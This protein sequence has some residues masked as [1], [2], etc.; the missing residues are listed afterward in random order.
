MP[1][2][3]GS[4]V[5]EKHFTQ[6]RL[7]QGND[8]YHAFTSEDLLLFREREEQINLHLGSGSPSLQSQSK[9]L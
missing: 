7:R 2:F 4:I 5:I 6:S 8:H 3:V 1:L 9:L